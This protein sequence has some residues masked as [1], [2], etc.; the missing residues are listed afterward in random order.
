MNSKHSFKNDYVSRGGYKLECLLSE[1]SD[2]ID[3]KDKIC[4]DIGSSTGGFVDCLLKFG[5]KKVYC[6]D[7]GKNLLDYRLKQDK[8]V[9]VFEEVN[10]RYFIELGYKDFVKEK[11]D[12]FT[13]DVSFISLEKIFPTILR[14]N[15]EY[16]NW[17]IIALVKPQF[18]CESK[19]LKKGVVTNIE[20]RFSAV[21]KISVFAQQLGLKEIFRM[22]SKVY[23]EEGNREY[24]L[25]FKKS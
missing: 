1:I 17:H 25:C 9:I 11:I 14:I 10:F 5:A 2:I 13:V 24:F 7:V 3:V 12:I 19:V 6:C 20:D 8:R 18:E 22:E 16:S 15:K 21:N 23:K 4:F